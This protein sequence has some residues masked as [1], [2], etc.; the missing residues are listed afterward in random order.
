MSFWTEGEELQLTLT[1]TR[2]RANAAGER[3]TEG[4]GRSARGRH[5]SD[6]KDRGEKE[7]VNHTDLKP[8]DR[9]EERLLKLA[10]PAGALLVAHTPTAA[11]GYV[12]AACCQQRLTAIII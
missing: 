4:E 9:K 7:R 5:G 3:V 11:F 8:R 12:E 2:V 10:L 6:R 1:D